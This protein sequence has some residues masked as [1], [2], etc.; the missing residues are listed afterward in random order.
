[1]KKIQM[2]FDGVVFNATGVSRHHRE[3]VKELI[4]R[5][6]ELHVFDFYDPVFD[7]TGELAKNCFKPI[8]YKDKDLITLHT[9]R[10]DMWSR[11]FGRRIGFPV[12]EGSKLPEGWGDI[13]NRTVERLM[14]PSKATKNLFVSNGVN[15]PVHVVPEGVDIETF[16]PEGEKREIES[17]EDK[18]DPFIFLSVNSWSGELNDRKGTDI[19]VKAF[20]EEFKPNENVMLFLKIS[21]FYLPP[22]DIRQA[23][24]RL[25]L[26]SK[27][28]L[29]AVDQTFMMPEELPKL[30]RAADC[31]ISATRGESWG[32]TIGEAMACGVPIILPKNYEAGYMDFVKDYPL[33]VE[34]GEKEQA[35]RRYF[36]EGNLMPRPKIES[37]RQKMRE[38]FEM[39]KEK[40]KQLGLEGSKY[41][42]ENYS[43][44]N[45]V[46]EMMEILK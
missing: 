16:K 19:L 15:I 37:L 40:R 7:P 43:W 35:D 2:Y 10:P 36:T 33:F 5:E 45:A 26:P 31:F 44:K 14:V 22:F 4:K 17:P 28:P 46:D 32:L 8:D 23:L 42:K 20:C 6:V 21:T 38:M 12:H 1:M 27:I 29:L 3:L 34:I 11:G 9:Y 30:Y 13:C 24:A 41:I 39:D 18:K 25:A